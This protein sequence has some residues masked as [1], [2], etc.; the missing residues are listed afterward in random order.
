MPREAEI[1]QRAQKQPNLLCFIEQCPLALQAIAR[2]HDYDRGPLVK[3]DYRP[4][5]LRHLIGAGEHPDHEAAV[6]WNALAVLELRERA[7]VAEVDAEIMR[8]ADAA[9]EVVQW[10]RS[11][12]EGG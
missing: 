3:G 10:L 7:R 2:V 1:A 5:L 4:S 9:E 11:T 12:P 6:A 8:L